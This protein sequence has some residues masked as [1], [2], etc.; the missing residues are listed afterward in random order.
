MSIPVAI[1][2]IRRVADGQ[3]G[4]AYLLTVGADG[5]PHAVAITP[6]DAPDG[7]VCAVGRTSAANAAARPAVS[8]VWPPATP[9]DYSLIVDGL[10][11][12]DGGTIT[13][14]PT[15]A[16]RHRPAADGGND[17]VRLDRPGS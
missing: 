2:E 15:G 3:A 12:V 14:R 9:D 11:E 8:L 1:D 5:R 16:V 7:L 10:A 6:T 17:C 13:V 4:F